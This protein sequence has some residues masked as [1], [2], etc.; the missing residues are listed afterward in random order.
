MGTQ[1]A[2][3]IWSQMAFACPLSVTPRFK[4]LV[5]ALT[6]ALQSPLFSAQFFVHDLMT[7]P[8]L[9]ACSAPPTSARLVLAHQETASAVAV[10]TTN[11][12]LSMA[13]PIPSPHFFLN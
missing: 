12:R 5:T 9:A 13:Q 2:L 3:D 10:D 8:R 11:V 1:G 4:S 6:K 7:R